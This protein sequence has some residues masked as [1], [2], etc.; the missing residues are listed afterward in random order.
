LAAVAAALILL[1]CGSDGDKGLGTVGYVE[2]F[3]GGVAAD[4]PKAAL[5]GREVLASGGSA[6][7]AVTAMYFAMAVTLPSQASLG[8][9]GVC[10][11]YDSENLE[12]RALEF[13]ARPPASV[14]PGADRPTGVPGNVR[15]F[16]AFHARFGR[17]RWS[18]L[19]APAE[20]LARFG[21]QV[22][23]A[24]GKDLNQVE[25]ALLTEPE[26]RGVFKSSNM[27][28]MIAEGDFMHQLDLASVISNIRSNG[29][30]GFYTGPLSRQLV[31]AVKSA[32][33]SLESSDLY[34]Y[35]PIW[36]DTIRLEL[37]RD[38]VHFT[39][40]PPAGGAV[41]AQMWAM[42][43]DGGRF[44][45]ASPEERPHL[46]AEVSLRA[47]SERER[48]AYDQ[49]LIGIGADELIADR[50]I[51]DL[52]QG[53]RP[54]QHVAPRQLGL[55]VKP[56]LEN[57]AAA[58]MVAVDRTGSAAACAVTLNSLFGT[59][60]IAP[61]TGIVLASVP[62]QGGRGASALGP[63]LVV[64]Q[65]IPKFRFAAAASGGAAAPV[66]MVGV[67]AETLLE[68]V[69]LQDAIAAKRVLGGGDPDVV[70]FEQLLPGPDL[71]SL[72]RRGHQLV[73]IL[74]VGKVN[75]ISCPGSIPDQ[76]ET[77]AAV[78]DP[79]GFGLAATAD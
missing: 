38:V 57:P 19:L 2:G 20:N 12:V 55:T 76:P 40:P 58:S 63:M 32:G 3:L 62:G 31:D 35:Q 66:A 49:G 44:A 56:L 46:M 68:G 27:E 5:V 9:G 39:P 71:Q 41:A 11:A 72:S 15:G 28:R 61:G 51:D 24:F 8:G 21:V 59:G 42:L 1:G 74:S 29:P 52:M 34:D 64:N 69:P 4:E 17:L 16:Y 43:E 33:G 54:D 36:R 50:H 18:Q 70:Y 48:W 6:A 13:L 26:T 60:R 53:Y 77:C 10:I 47:F 25:N 22:S 78:T 37:G 75:A 30:G 14:S 45:D 67:A 65:N 23:R 7:D 79:R 73:Q